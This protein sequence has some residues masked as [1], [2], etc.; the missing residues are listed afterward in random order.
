MDLNSFYL[1][2]RNSVASRAAADN[3]YLSM[4]YLS[5]VADRLT[6]AEEIENLTPL[7]FEGVGNRNRL[8]SVSGFDLDDTDGSI[9]LAVLV[10]RGG[11]EMGTIATTDI[12]RA[13]TSLKNYLEE[14]VGGTFQAGREESSEAWQLAGDLYNRGRNVTR[15]RLYLITDLRTTDRLRNL[16]SDDLNSTPVDYRIWDIGRLHQLYESQQGREELEIDLTEWMTDGLPVLNASSAATEFTTFLACVPGDLIADLYERYGSRLLE[17]NVRSFLSSRGV[18]NRG[19]RRTITREP[20]MFLAFNNGITATATGVVRGASGCLSGVRDLQ[21]VN[22]GQTTA[23]LY[24]LRRDQGKSAAALQD[25]AVQMKLVVVEKDVAQEL[26]SRISRYAN[27]QNRVSEADFFSNSPFHIRMEEISRRV[28]APVEGSN[29]FRTKWFYERVRGQYQNE[30]SRRS[31]AEAKK[32]QLTFPKS[33]II[34]KT[35]AARYAVSWDMKPHRVSAGAQRNFVEFAESIVRRWEKSEDE[36]NEEY[37]KELVAKAI[38]YRRVRWLV[39][40]A[41]WYEQGYLANIVSFAIAKLSHEVEASSSRLDFN[42]IWAS[43]TLPALL[44]EVMLELAMLA[45]KALTTPSR[46]LANVTEWAKA[47]DCWT[48]LKQLDWTPPAD[49]DSLLVSARDAAERRVN[50]AQIQRIDSG[51]AAQ[52]RVLELRAAGALMELRAFGLQQ[53]ALSPK[54]L[55]IVEVGAGMK[56]T[57]IPSE[58]Q[59]LAILELLK[60][61]EELGFPAP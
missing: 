48:Y 34:T 37:F 59:S 9:A 50:A 20:E 5:E 29:S 53:G 10:F 12:R 15:Y 7:H 46:R 22:G 27:S 28:L 41:P 31:A 21:I 17:S 4:A 6:D 25:V 57:G 55:N 2:V 56:G 39:S 40:H 14:A 23:S 19:M 8:L 3:Q 51:I 52:T 61:C 13:F 45:L 58:R 32:F 1:D 43:Q 36:F 11:E 47:E 16:E 60:R 44:D 26:V 30:L 38:L 35:D 33:H 49:F 54:E 24:Y 18:V 42:Q